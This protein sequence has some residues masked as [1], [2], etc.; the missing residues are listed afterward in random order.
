MSPFHCNSTLRRGPAGRGDPSAQN[1]QRVLPRDIIFDRRFLQMCAPIT[2][3]SKKRCLVQSFRSPVS[4]QTIKPS[5][6]QIPVT[7]PRRIHM[8]ARH[9]ASSQVIA[10]HSWRHYLAERS[11]PQRP[12]IGLGR[13]QRQRVW[14]GKRL[15]C[16]ARIPEQEISR[17]PHRARL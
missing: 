1:A 13:G 15:G 7:W 8:V 3:Y 2:N 14:Q 9:C 16:T 17:D 10:P 11:S 6:W 4:R 5:L 12:A